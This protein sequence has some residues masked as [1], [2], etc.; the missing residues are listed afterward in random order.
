MA[1]I[2]RTSN[3]GLTRSVRRGTA[4]GSTP[5]SRIRVAWEMLALALIV[6]LL[7]AVPLLSRGTDVR[8]SDDTASVLVGEGDTLW[9]LAKSNPV[10]GLST[11]ENVERIAAMNGIESGR[12]PVGSAIEVPAEQGVVELA[13]K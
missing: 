13:C 4:P 8:D 1:S 6:V 11:E 2:T 12:L 3:T 5:V 9:S 7:V 10:P